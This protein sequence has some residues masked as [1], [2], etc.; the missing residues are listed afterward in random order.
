MEM[1]KISSNKANN[2]SSYPIGVSLTLIIAAILLSFVDLTFLKEVLEKVLDLSDKFGLNIIIPSAIGLVGIA[3]MAHE[4][5]R[6]AHSDIHDKTSKLAHYG[7]WILLGF[8]IVIT[9]IFSAKILGLSPDQGG[10]SLVKVFNVYVRQSDIVTTPLMFLLYIATGIMVR[11][12]VKNLLTHPG[13]NEWVKGVKDFFTISPATKTIKQFDSYI[14]EGDNE[15][16]NEYYDNAIT[17]YNRALALNIDNDH[18]RIAK[19]K[20]DSA[21]ELK[22]VAISSL[23]NSDRYRLYLNA[24][25]IYELQEQ[26]IKDTYT[27]INNN[28]GYIIEIDREER[29]YEEKVKPGLIKIISQSIHS[30]QNTVA[31][32]IREKTNCGI[33]ELRETIEEYNKLNEA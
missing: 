26:K 20:I 24:L 3:I 11:D 31:L 9:R 5:I 16:K 28:I 7:L 2:K 12:G 8:S 17:I 15:I 14:S 18:N 19:A 25:N 13:Y 30:A 1:N 4:G 27:L 21:V 23:D 22:K 10:D 29:N 6:E 32:M 33:Q